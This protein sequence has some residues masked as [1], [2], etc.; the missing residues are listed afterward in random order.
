[1]IQLISDRR[2]DAEAATK[3]DSRAREGAHAGFFIQKG[4]MPTRAEVCT[5]A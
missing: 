1:M 4:H 2:A 3:N 5:V